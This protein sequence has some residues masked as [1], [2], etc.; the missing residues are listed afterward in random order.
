MP[1]RKEV[2]WGCMVEPPL[3]DEAVAEAEA[4]N[5]END[6]TTGSIT[7]AVELGGIPYWDARRQPD[8]EGSAAAAAAAGAGTAGVPA[9]VEPIQA[10]AAAAAAASGSQE[11]NTVDITYLKTPAN[12]KPTST[13]ADKLG[14]QISP[15][16]AAALLAADSDGK[17]FTL[18][19]V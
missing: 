3:P 1:S 6:G 5:A 11:S 16:S 4:L 14:D 10:A 19:Y 18:Q 2:W 15:P 8:T 17:S 12:A 9:A 7:R 13:I